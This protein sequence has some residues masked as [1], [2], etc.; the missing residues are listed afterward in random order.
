MGDFS[1]KPRDL[2][3]VL[4]RTDEIAEGSQGQRKIG[5]T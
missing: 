5:E 1:V 2:V 4:A 3:T